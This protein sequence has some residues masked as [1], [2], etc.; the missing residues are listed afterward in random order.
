M[1]H[2]APG[3]SRWNFP[4]PKPAG[5][6]GDG[7]FPMGGWIFLEF[8]LTKGRGRFLV[9]GETSW[10]WR[11]IDKH[12]GDEDILERYLGD[13]DVRL[14]FSGITPSVV[15]LKKNIFIPDPWGDDPI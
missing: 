7:L 4:T 14:C 3:N 5:Q 12:L 10:R 6:L 1:D 15:V 8:D 9:K 2:G 13:E 11:Y